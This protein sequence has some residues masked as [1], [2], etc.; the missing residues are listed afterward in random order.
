MKKL[1]G[2]NYGIEKDE[3]KTMGLKRYGV[4]IFGVKNIGSKDVLM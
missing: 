2:K 4:K 3:V 1:L